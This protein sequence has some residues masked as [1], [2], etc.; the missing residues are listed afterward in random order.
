[1]KSAGEREELEVRVG[2]GLGG[3]GYELCVI[4]AAEI[5]Q[6]PSGKGVQ[7][8]T[9]ALG[10][11]QRDPERADARESRLKIFT[12][13]F[14]AIGDQKR[15]NEDQDGNENAAQKLIVVKMAD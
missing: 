1:M 4:G 11:E 8:A 15:G 12:L 14:A 5:G 13:V 2:G 6:G 9:A 3:D 7:F 10:R